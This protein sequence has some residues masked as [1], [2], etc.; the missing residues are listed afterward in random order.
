MTETWR[1]S[2][3]AGVAMSTTSVAV[4][5]A[6]MLEFGLNV[7]SYGTLLMATGLIF[8]TISALFALSH[9]VTTRAQ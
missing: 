4:V 9:G 1:A 3:L 8:G 5:Y 6:V 7:T 2:W